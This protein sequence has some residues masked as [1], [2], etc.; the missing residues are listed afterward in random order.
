MYL[1]SPLLHFH[2]ASP[3]KVPSPHNDLTTF[4]SLPS[5]L[6]P[7]LPPASRDRWRLRETLD[8]SLLHL[9]HLSIPFLDWLLNSNP[10]PLNLCI[11]S[12]H[13][14]EPFPPSSTPRNRFR[15][16]TGMRQE[17]GV[18]GNP[19]WRRTVDSRQ[20]AGCQGWLAWPNA[21][22]SPMG[23]SLRQE[24]VEIW[25]IHCKYTVYR[26]QA[27][28]A[29]HQP[30][31]TVTQSIKISSRYAHRH[32]ASRIQRKTTV[33]SKEAGHKISIRRP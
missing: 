21:S 10:A 13:N 30:S 27:A 24:L 15:Y 1:C 8:R 22:N 9:P 29:Q 12:K 18:C 2:L 11:D 23:A 6:P 5:T 16:T 4:F 17:Q 20:G 32:T 7:P 28:T 31:A 25:P 19:E 33:F 14:E 3:P 26:A